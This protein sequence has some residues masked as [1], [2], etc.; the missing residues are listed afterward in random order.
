METHQKKDKADNDQQIE[1]N[2]IL[3][4]KINVR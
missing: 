3:V 2:V 1:M 4:I